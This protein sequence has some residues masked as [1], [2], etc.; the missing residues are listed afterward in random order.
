MALERGTLGW[1]E[2]E[3]YMAQLRAFFFFRFNN[4]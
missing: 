3:E 4:K 1:I 2:L